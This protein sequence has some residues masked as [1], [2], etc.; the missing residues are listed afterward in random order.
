[1]PA[2]YTY[3][4]VYIEEVPSGVRPISGVSTSNTAFVDRF[5]R[6][7]LNSPRRVESFAEF[8]R[9]YGGLDAS[10]ESSYAVDQ[11]F[12]HGG[13]VAYIVRVA[14]GTPAEASGSQ[15]ALTIAG[16]TPGTWA[17]NLFFIITHPDDAPLFTLAVEERRGPH[18]VAREEY[19]GLALDPAHARYAP[20]VVN[21]SSEL[22]RLTHN[23]TTT[24]TRPAVNNGTAL[25]GGDNGGDPGQTQFKAGWETLDELAPEVFNLLCL[26]G[27]ARLLN[28]A[29][30]KS[31]VTDA[32]K[33]VRDRRAF[34]LI[35][36]PPTSGSVDTQLTALTSWTK[37]AIL[38][39]PN[40]ALYFPRMTIP[41]PLNP[42][43][44]RTIGSS[45]AVAGL[46]AATDTRRGVWKAPAGT[47]AVLGGTL[48]AKLTDL[49]N[50]QLNV[51]GVNVLRSFPIYGNLVWGS[52]TTVGADAQASEWKYVPVRRTA[53]YI[54]ESLYQGLKWVVFEP[55]DQPL[56]SS[57]ELNVGAFMDGLF[58]QG[59]FAGE[60]PARAY[61]VKCDKD[62]TTPADVDRGIVNILVGFAPLKPAEFV[63]LKIQQ[64]AGQSQA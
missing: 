60:T 47:D 43:Q 58:R 40:S 11:Y 48:A 63:V 16:K 46:Y 51:K 42:G 6:G 24:T 37:N 50:G 2:Q 12:A 36:S 55:N 64:L 41:D 59:A 7:P 25:G 53:L 9:L 19:A 38:N 14:S 35:D 26:P 44:S 3:P 18:V 34:L 39:S 30:H 49:Q 22:V 61:L 33:Y 57:I 21:P 56:W 31:V 10:S 1:M 32:T 20:T 8:E 5:N 15:D 28:E 29:N 13:G 4:G 54:E 45:G 62:T 23:P 17:R 52:R 27:A